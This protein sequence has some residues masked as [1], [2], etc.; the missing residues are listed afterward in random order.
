LPQHLLPNKKFWKNSKGVSGII[1][2]IFLVM[3]ILF[4][5]ANVF[6]FIQRENT[7][8]QDVVSEVNQMD[9]DRSSEKLIVSNLNYTVVEDKVHVEAQVT[10][11]GAVSIQIITIW[12][13]DKTI[14]KYGHNDTLNIN[15]KTGDTLIFTESNALRVTIKGSS[16]SNVF[17]SW[18][19]T[20][21]GNLVPLEEE[22]GIIV[23]QL[24]QGIGSLA[25]DF[26]KFRYFTYESPQKL[27][28]YPTGTVSFNVPKNEYV[29][30]GC[31]LTNLDPS[32]QTIT[33]DSH[34]LFWQPGRPGVAEGA[35]FIVNVNEDGTINGAYSPISLKYGETKM[36]VFASQNDLALGSFSR[37]K[38]PNTVTTVA[39]FLLL[40]GTLGSTAY[41]QNIP[42]VSLFYN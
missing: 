19:V 10:N 17:T 11:D 21:R 8:F 4:L 29:A 33:I 16:S 20:V 39:T 3:I 32:K 25:L 34:S 27:S 41:A 7:R 9:I 36:F 40:H 28:N 23:A 13:V 26:E 18:F 22:Q 37:A 24:A 1:A 14:Q 42:F 2:T 6:I 5:Y 35:W 30:F 38:T 31:Y 15:L 12:V